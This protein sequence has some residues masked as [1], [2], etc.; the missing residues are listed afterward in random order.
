MR[1]FIAILF[2]ISCL[3]VLIFSYSAWKDK[4]QAAGVQNLEA[5]VIEEQEITTESD[6]SE[7]FP[8]LDVSVLPKDMN[9]EV[10]S[11]FLNRSEARDIVQVLLVGSQAMDSGSPGYAELFTKSMEDAY[12]GFVEV[13]SLASD[14]TSAAFIEEKIDLS[15]GYDLVIL[16]PFTLNNNGLVEIEREHAH[17]KE[18]AGRITSEVEDAVLLLQPPQPIYG[19]Q[20]YL[21]QVKSLEKFA[22]RQNYGYINHWTAWPDTN[23]IALKT[24]LT[25]NGSPAQQG[26][27]AWA[28]ELGTYFIAE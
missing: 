1:K 25:D 16:E 19:A 3:A 13:D 28:T 21:T 14:G 8:S 9:T 15:A 26:A 17:I 22:L 24:Y 10:R 18:F 23:D 6:T 27:E 2:V 11:L 12:A 4:I 7:S 5:S 20:F